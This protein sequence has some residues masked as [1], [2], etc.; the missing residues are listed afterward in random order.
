MFYDEYINWWPVT[1]F[2]KIFIYN[3]QNW[4][5][6]N[7]I[8]EIDFLHILAKVLKIQFSIRQKSREHLKNHRQATKT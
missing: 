2:I 8:H 4:G 6:L 5:N 7:F 3:R 1:L